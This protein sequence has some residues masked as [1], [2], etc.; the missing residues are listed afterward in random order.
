MRLRRR[1]S[2]GRSAKR[3]L[4]QEFFRPSSWSPDQRPSVVGLGL[5]RRWQPGAE[6]RRRAVLIVKLAAEL[7]RRE[8]GKLPANA[9]LLLDGYLKELPAG[10]KPDDPFRRELMRHCRGGIRKP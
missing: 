7:Y 10:I 4:A 3:L 2:T 6:P 9:G 8:Q 1:T 5:G